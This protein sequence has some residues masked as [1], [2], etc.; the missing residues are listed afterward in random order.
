MGN[1]LTY[2]EVL[3]AVRP[4][5]EAGAA[6]HWLVPRGKMPIDSKW[7][8]APRYDEDNLHDLYKKGANIGLRTGEPSKIGDLYLH[9]LDVDIRVSELASE[10][11]AAVEEM[12]PNYKDFPVVI[13]GSGGESRHIYFFSAEPL[14]SKKLRKSKGFSF[15]HDSKKARDVKK[16][17]WEIDI[18]GTG[19]QVAI[20]PSIHPDTGKPYIWDRELDLI[21]PELDEIPMSDLDDWGARTM[22]YA[23]DDEDDLGAILRAEPMDID[24]E[25]VDEI[26]EDL[27]ED[28][29]EDRDEWYRVGMALHHQY[30]GDEL[31][32]E[33]WTRWSK[34]SSKFDADNQRYIWNSFKGSSTPIRMATLIQAVNNHKLAESIDFEIE[35][36]GDAFDEEDIDLDSD[37]IELNLDDDDD[38][39]LDLDDIDLDSPET[40]NKPYEKLVPTAK[41]YQEVLKPDPNWT[42]KLH[43]TDEGELKNT[44]PNIVLILQND[45]RFAG[46][47]AFNEFSNEVVLKKKPPR[48]KK[49]AKAQHDPVNLSG[50]IWQLDDP[51]NG[52]NWTDDHDSDIRFVIE[53]KSTLNGYGIKIADRDLRA[54]VN[55][56]AQQN[57]FHPV[58]DTIEAVEWDGNCRC[59]TLFIDYLGC[60]DNSYHRQASLMTMVG[61]IARIY[62]PGCKFDFVPILEGTQGKG[63]STF[64]QILGLKW[65]R[66][67]QGDVGNSKEMV[68]SMQGAWILEIGELSSMH[69]AEVNDLKSFVSRQV[70]KVRL[71]YEKRA[72]DFRRVCIFIGSTNDNEYLRDQTGGR[73]FW[74]I[75]CLLQGMIDNKRLKR[76]ISQIWAEALQIYLRMREKAGTDELPLHLTGDAADTATIV[77]ESRRLESPEEVMA[78]EIKAW[79][80]TPLNDEF[81]D[82]DGD[83]MDDRE[84]EL[85]N[86]TCIAQVWKEMMGRQGSPPHMDSMRIGKALQLIGWERSKGI[87][88]SFKINKKYGPCRIYSRN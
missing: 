41:T 56:C 76:E 29:V 49:K 9:V 46:I 1:S 34:Q 69:R 80:E 82:A 74:P 2:N 13:S 60:E 33:K 71:S 47:M 53:S 81:D 50:R 88:K 3:S 26:L 22:S 6:L 42:Q 30:S 62:E 36:D 35:T 14:R 52:N 12:L 68:E 44:L 57:A 7:T 28:W 27:P 31:G 40:V 45:P 23:S 64:I 5:I 58:K 65:M 54:A 86:E 73:R 70:D 85:R 39:E 84:P 20:P 32:Y 63:K 18:K 19:T 15:V 66:E 67:L 24:D 11:W 38:L 21:S 51:I 72:R 25:R 55:K 10:A 37:D 83:L 87:V 59:E 8:S 61:A 17:D 4:L 79:L 77:Q 16:F 75:V 78:G 43:R 48:V